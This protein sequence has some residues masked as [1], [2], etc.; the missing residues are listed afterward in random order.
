DMRTG[1]R[2]PKRSAEQRQRPTSSRCATYP[3]ARPLR[4]PSLRACPWGRRS[5]CRRAHETNGARPSVRRRQRGV[6]RRRPLTGA[7]CGVVPAASLAPRIPQGERRWGAATAVERTLGG[8][9]PGQMLLDHADLA[10]QP[11]GLV[12][13][14]RTGE[15]ITIDAQGVGP[16][17]ELLVG[18]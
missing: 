17:T 12:G 11:L 13:I 4:S 3:V 5:A 10:L 7:P 18:V 14:L 15:R 1:A 6:P 2:H 8:S 16:P 9:R